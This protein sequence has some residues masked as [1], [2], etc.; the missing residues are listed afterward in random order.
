MAAAP[1]RTG[2]RSFR[3]TAD[4]VAEARQ[5]LA[6]LL[7]DCPFAVDAVACLSELAANSVLHS[8]SRRPGGCFTVRASLRPAGLRV[9]V[10]DEG[11]PWGP[12]QEPDD[13]CGRGFVI[14]GALSSDWSV[15]GDETSR[16]IWF[17]L[18]SLPGGQ[19]E[20]HLGD[21]A[22]VGRVAGAGRP[23]LLDE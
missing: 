8:N 17:E 4:Q 14:V 12:R 1:P 9:E 16:I 2:A 15:T 5:F 7:G 10:E 18:G 3:A 23:E 6:Q 21:V 22:D 13:E 20:V 11:G 19:H